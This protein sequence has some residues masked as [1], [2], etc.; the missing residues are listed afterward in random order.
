VLLCGAG[1][2]GV[3]GTSLPCGRRVHGLLLLHPLGLDVGLGISTLLVDRRFTGISC[4]LGVEPSSFHLELLLSDGQLNFVPLLFGLGFQ[5]L[6]LLEGIRLVLMELG[7][8]LEGPVPE[9]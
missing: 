8:V 2:V 7:L 3:S 6:G 4:G 1:L 9:D 5:A